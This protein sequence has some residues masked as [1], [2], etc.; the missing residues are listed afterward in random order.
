MI[1]LKC[2]G[3]GFV[4]FGFYIIY[5]VIKFKIWE[6]EHGGFEDYEDFRLF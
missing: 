1:I 2:L 5:Q 4:I 3:T 6:K